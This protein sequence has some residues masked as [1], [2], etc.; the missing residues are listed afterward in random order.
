MVANERGQ[1]PT[2]AASAAGRQTI[3]APVGGADREIC[4]RLGASPPE[5][6]PSAAIPRATS[7]SPI[8]P[9]ISMVTTS[10][11]E[12]AIRSLDVT[13]S[14]APPSLTLSVIALSGT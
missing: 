9:S 2:P 8:V 3:G 12:V 10:S 5:R 4:E 6:A 7:I 13:C 14:I 1:A 11:P